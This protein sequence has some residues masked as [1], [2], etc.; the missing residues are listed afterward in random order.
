MRT[1]I[2]PTGAVGT[3]LL[4]PLVLLA[5]CESDSSGPNTGPATGTLQ[6]NASSNSGYTYVRFEGDSL[7][8]VANPG[9]TEWDLALR[10]YTVK[11]NGGVG[12]PKGVLGYNLANNAAADTATILSFTP[13]NTLAAFEAIGAGDVPADNQ[14]AGED[15]GPDFASWFRF[16]PTTNGLIANPQASWKVQRPN[17]GGYALVRVIRMVATQAT[18]DS[19]EFEWR[20]ENAGVLGAAQTKVVGTGGGTIGL[21]FGTGNQVAATGCGWDVSADVNFIVTVNSGCQAG[22]FPLDVTQTF[23]GTTAA[24]D[25]PE[26]GPFLARISG[27]IPSSFSDPEAPFLYDL[28]ADQRLSPTFNTYLI[29]VGTDTWKL[30]LIDYYSP[31]GQSG[32]PTLRFQRIQ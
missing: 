23:A 4:L 10:R 28:A 3:A 24:S 13:S 8:V 5:A 29:K 20:L 26:Y 11:L 27:P 6:V 14:F 25:A 22:S 7:V 2:R 19:V 9:A 15:L 17:S 1:A 21:D 31:T 30:Q 32:Y 12:G 18:L 16:D